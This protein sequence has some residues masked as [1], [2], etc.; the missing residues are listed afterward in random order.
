MDW[1]D[2]AEEEL[3]DQLADG[4]IT[5]DQFKRL[6]RELRQEVQESGLYD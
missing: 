4:E 2:R 5:K 1:A 3:Q 6:M